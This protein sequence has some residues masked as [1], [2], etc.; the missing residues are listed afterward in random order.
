MSAARYPSLAGRR[1]FVTGGA[2]GIGAAIVRAFVG[3]DARV[4]FIDLLE[5]E[6][7]ALAAETGALFS[8]CDVTAPGALAMAVAEAGEALGGLDA[9][10][11]NVANDARH[12][13]ATLSDEA[14][15][16]ALAVNLD[17]AFIAARAAYPLVKAAG[18]GA[19]VNLSSINA[20]LGPGDLVAYDA[21]KGGVNALTKGLARAW[22][23]DRIRVN[24]IAPGWVVTERQLALWL[25]PEAEAEWA[26]LV[27]L[28]DRIAPEDVAALA[29]F[30]AADESR[31][32]TGQV[33]AVDAGRT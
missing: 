5:G 33:I 30:L 27:A 14:W 11:N 32:I 31:M 3:Q 12:D 6:G 9:L 10:V 18:G 25:T 4:A 29:L 28:P 21:A 17:P 1:V 22:G 15:R 26:K 8:R 7:Q 16:A 13:A 24:A 19:I 23:A 20:V 2:T